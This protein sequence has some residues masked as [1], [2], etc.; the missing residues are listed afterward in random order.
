MF[1]TNK[2]MISMKLESTPYTANDASSA[3]ANFRADSVTYT[4][5]I[6]ETVRKYATGDFASYASVMGKREMKIGFSMDMAQGTDLTTAPEWEK[7]LMACGF[8]KTVYAGGLAYDLCSTNPAAPVSILVPELN[9]DTTEGLYV[10][11]SGCMGSVKLALAKIG[12]PLKMSFEFSG[13]FQGITDGTNFIHGTFQQTTPNAVLSS[14]ITAFAET[15]DTEK[16]D[17]DVGNK[18]EQVVDPSKA[19]GIRGYVITGRE[20]KLV[21]DPYLASIATRGILARWQN[22]TQGAF[23][24]TVG[25]NL[26]ISAPDIQI[27]KAFEGG[28]RNGIVVNTLNC[29]LNRTNDS[30]DAELR[31]LQGVAA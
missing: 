20:P 15:L 26:T 16:V 2:R 31:I 28:D 17:I 21:V 13:V 22:G 9:T 19:A 12:D 18:V 24:M 25:S 7:P 3:D 14:T 11:A 1:L 27:T 30:T 5:A 29:R 10:R 23:S 6:A 8:K 4:P